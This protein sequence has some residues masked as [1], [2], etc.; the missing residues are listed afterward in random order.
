MDISREFLV[1]RGRIVFWRSVSKV[2]AFGL[3]HRQGLFHAL[4]LAP[5]AIIALAAF[6]VGRGFGMLIASGMF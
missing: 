2:T 6:I 5:I 1:R 3:R 4:S